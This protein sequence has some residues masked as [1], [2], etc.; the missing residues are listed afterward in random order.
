MKTRSSS[1]EPLEFRI[2]PAAVATID[3]GTLNGTN[4]FTIDGLDVQDFSGT[5]LGRAGDVNGDGIEDL[6]LSAVGGDPNGVTDA[7]ETYVIFGR[8][9]GFGTKFDLTTLDGTNGFRIDG[10]AMDDNSGAAINGAGDLNGDGFADLVIGAQFADPGGRQDAGSVYVVFGKASGFAAS[11]N[12]SAPDGVNVSRLDGAAAG[13]RLGSDVGSA[14]DFNGDG[15]ADLII[16]AWFADNGGLNNT[17][18]TYIVFGKKTGLAPVIDLAALN[19]TAG[20]TL[21]GV[22]ADDR[23]GQEISGI[24]D[25]NRDGFD[26]VLIAAPGGDPVGAMEGGECY[27]VFG[28]A[29]PFVSSLSLGALNGSNGFQIPGTAAFEGLGVRLNGAGDLNRDGFPDVVLAGGPNQ[30]YVVFGKRG[31]FNS[32]FDLTTLDGTNGFRIDG[33]TPNDSAGSDVGAAGDFNGDGFGDLLIAAINAN[34]LGRQL[35]GSAYVVFG[36][37]GGFPAS[38]NLATLDGHNGIRFDG[39][40]A[41]EALGTVSATGDVNG[42]GYDD[43]LLGSGLADPGGHADAGRTYVVYGFSDREAKIATDGHSATYLDGD[44]DLVSVK[45]SHG[46]LKQANFMLVPAAYV[47]GGSL[48]RHLDLSDGQFAGA[49]V[50]ITAVHTK[51]GGDG[52]VNVG[53][54]DATGINLG[55]V[56]VKGDLGDLEAGAG[57]GIA[58]ASLSVHSLGAYGLATQSGTGNLDWHLNGDVGAFKVT[59]DV[60]DGSVS[61]LGSGGPLTIGGIAPRRRRGESTAQRHP[62]PRQWGRS[63]R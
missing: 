21:L 39:A 63:A 59:A 56:V 36:K 33:A 24:G 45:V 35:A 49:N 12:L 57:D 28:H 37:P 52:L 2:A 51:L 4:G 42:D 46:T 5:W 9:G 58:V 3:L 1:P 13:D 38:F 7:G 8:A 48:L 40:A 55:K 54:L 31:P 41:F 62:R 19:G 14:G 26:D 34:P 27:V 20:F 10:L 44:G 53:F 60:K 18:A 30:T 22:G 50:T 23:S 32:S 11:V 6:L 25:F 17:G 47:E 29:A 15:V 61:I 43:I 16:G